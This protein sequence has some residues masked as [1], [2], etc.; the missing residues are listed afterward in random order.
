[1]V[2]SLSVNEPLFVRLLG[3]AVITKPPTN[4]TVQEGQGVEF[5]CEGQASPKNV[6]IKWFKDGRPLET[7]ADLVS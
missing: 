7:M 4:Q 6:S 1:M 5:P 3:G 2:S